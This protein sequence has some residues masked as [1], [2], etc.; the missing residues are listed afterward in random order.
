MAKMT[1]MQETIEMPRSTIIRSRTTA[2]MLATDKTAPAR[3]GQ[4]SKRVLNSPNV[5]D[6]REDQ[7]HSILNFDSSTALN[8]AR[9]LMG[10]PIRQ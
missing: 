2:K 9:D 8:W 4:A 5:S 10:A 1:T 6:E 3:K 7:Q